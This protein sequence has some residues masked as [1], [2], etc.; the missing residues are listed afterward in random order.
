VGISCGQQEQQLSFLEHVC[1]LFFLPF[2]TSEDFYIYWD[3]FSKPH[4]NDD[5]GNWR[6]FELLRVFSAVKNLYLS[7]EF[8]KHVA[9]ALQEL[10]VGGTTQM[11][12]NLQN[13]F[14]ESSRPSKINRDKTYPPPFSFGLVTLSPDISYATFL[15]ITMT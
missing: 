13:L 1:T 4:W 11:L 2:P 5:L 7:K 6:W 3:G 15:S 9:P 12:P 8:T 10:V 14:L